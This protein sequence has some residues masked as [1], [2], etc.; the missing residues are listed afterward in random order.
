MHSSVDLATD[1][2]NLVRCVVA[3]ERPRRSMSD[4]LGGMFRCKAVVVFSF[5]GNKNCVRIERMNSSSTPSSLDVHIGVCNLL[6]DLREL[7]KEPFGYTPSSVAGVIVNSFA[8]G[9]LQ[10]GEQNDI[11]GLEEMGGVARIGD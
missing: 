10:R 9:F 11:E 1:I 8:V 5:E 4:R 7:P 3:E 2:A 6:G